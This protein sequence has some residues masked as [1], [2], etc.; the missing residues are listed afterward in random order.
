MRPVRL[1]GAYLH[2]VNFLAFLDAGHFDLGARAGSAQ[3]GSGKGQD[4]AQIDVLVADRCD[5]L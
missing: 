4:A 1:Y 3:A 5:V 2:E